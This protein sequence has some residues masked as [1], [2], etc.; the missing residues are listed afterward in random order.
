[1]DAPS[2]AAQHVFRICS[3]QLANKQQWKMMV[4]PWALGVES[5][6]RIALDLTYVR[7]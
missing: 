2:N 1:V 7:V 5:D 6:G 3:E 4:S